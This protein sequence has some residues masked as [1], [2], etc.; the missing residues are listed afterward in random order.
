MI[1]Q[2]VTIGDRTKGLF[3]ISRKGGVVLFGKS[4]CK[5]RIPPSEPPINFGTPPSKSL[6]K[7][8]IPPSGCRKLI[9]AAGVNRAKG[10][11]RAAGNCT[12]GIFCFVL[13]LFLCVKKMDTPLE[14]SVKFLYPPLGNLVGNGYPPSKR[15]TPPHEKC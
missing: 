9:R 10:A 5:K 3:R 14:V 11:S 2:I 15:T 12:K 8:G 13:F 1:G 7:M 4:A 6:S